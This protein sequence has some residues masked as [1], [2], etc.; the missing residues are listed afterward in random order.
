MVKKMKQ[1]HINPSFRRLSKMQHLFHWF[2]FFNKLSCPMYSAGNR[3][4][5][6]KKLY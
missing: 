3:A 5:P 2:F 1:L 4:G 6:E